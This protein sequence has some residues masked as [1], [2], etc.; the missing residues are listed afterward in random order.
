M[1]ELCD[2]LA[3]AASDAII[4]L[5]GMEEAFNT[6][7]VG[8]DG[9]DTKLIDD[10]AEKAVLDVLRSDGRSIRILSEEL[11]EIIIG[12]EPEFTIV[13]DPL[14]GTYN[15]A[16]D[17]PIYGISI[18]IG[19]PD[20][21]AIYFGYVQNLA[22][23]DTFYASLGEGAYYNG[24]RISPSECSFLSDFC[25]SL[26]GYRKH[27]DRTVDLCKNVRRIRI[28]GSVSL[29]LCYVASGRLDAFVDV[30]GS[31][32]LVDVAAGIL[33]IEESGGTVTDGNG[34]KLE[35]KDSIM[36]PVYMIASNGCAHSNILKLVKR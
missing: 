16:N 17:I 5:V 15:V 36:N 18:A 21:S 8:A 33:I 27:V 10:V 6:V 31:L 12:D 1:F 14:D 20:L 30:R 35:L 25:L 29:E 34:N 23:G 32:R 19:K 28:F 7:Y 4:D 22:N 13:L 9:T 24:K 11:G 2:S 26:Y 3:K